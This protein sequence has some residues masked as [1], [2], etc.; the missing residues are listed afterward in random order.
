[1][2]TASIHATEGAFHFDAEKAYPASVTSAKHDYSRIRDCSTDGTNNYFVQ[3]RESS[4]T[5]LLGSLV[6]YR[7]GSRPNNRS[8]LR[9]L[10]LFYTFVNSTFLPPFSFPRFFN[11][12][13]MPRR[14]RIKAARIFS[15]FSIIF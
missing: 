13:G 10:E 6:E 2:I 3:T 9:H 12:Y 5:K 7:N 15:F 14:E 1:M 4:F 8:R 11:L